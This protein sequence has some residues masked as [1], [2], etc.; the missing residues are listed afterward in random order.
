MIAVDHSPIA[1]D[2]PEE[3]IATEPIEARGQR[4]DDAR[5]LV[6]WRSS[7]RLVDTCF[8]DLPRFLEAGESP[9]AER[10]DVPAST[11][12]LVN[13]ARAHGHRVVAV[14]TTATRAIETVADDDGR[15]RAGRGWTDVV[16]TPEVGVRAIDGLVSGWHEPQ[17]SH[18]QLIE[19]VAGRSLVER[20]YAHALDRGY[21]WHEFGD[22]FLVLP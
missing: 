6:A 9:Y 1:F 21:R 17:A 8:A 12:E 14:G 2:L 10:Y 20:S 13:D 22:L 7:G 15:V 4:R 11:A 18:L 16:I 3:R 5:L 19:A